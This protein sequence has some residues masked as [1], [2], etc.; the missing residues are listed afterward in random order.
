M[1]PAHSPRVYTFQT[2]TPYSQKLSKRK[3]ATSNGVRRSVKL[4][5]R[6]GSQL[7]PISL[8]SPRKP[9]T[10]TPSTDKIPQNPRPVKSGSSASLSRKKPFWETEPK[11]GLTH[12][13]FEEKLQAILEA[14]AREM[15][16]EALSVSHSANF[17]ESR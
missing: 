4:S 9:V 8:T 10:K 7:P 17:H 5:S 11:L 2:L 1:E 15:Q 12:E 16:T 13:Q 14:A 6:V 3:S